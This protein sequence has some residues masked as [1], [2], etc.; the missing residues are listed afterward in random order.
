MT[1][2]LRALFSDIAVQPSPLS[3]SITFSSSQ[4]ETLFPLNAYSPLPVLAPG[5]H[6]S[7]CLY[8]FNYS[9]CLM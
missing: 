8:K 5:N 7:P 2:I 1:N 4:S 6:R 3:I 9:R